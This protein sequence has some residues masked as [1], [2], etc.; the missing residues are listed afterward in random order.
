MLGSRGF[1]KVLLICSSGGI[2][3]GHRLEPLLTAGCRRQ[4]ENENREVTKMDKRENRIIE[5][6]CLIAVPVSMA[7]T[8]VLAQLIL[9]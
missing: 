7:L 4:N 8:M 5:T 6:C 3:D 2:S 1:D 9:G